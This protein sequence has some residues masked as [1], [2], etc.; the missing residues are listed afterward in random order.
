MVRESAVRTPH[1]NWKVTAVLVYG[2]FGL[3]ACDSK[4]SLQKPRHTPNILYTRILLVRTPKGR[5]HSCLE[6]IPNRPSITPYKAFQTLVLLGLEGLG[7]ESLDLGP[8]MRS[9]AGSFQIGFT[10]CSDQ[11]RVLGS[12]AQGFRG[13]L[14]GPRATQK[15]IEKSCC[16]GGDLEPNVRYSNRAA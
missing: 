2:G 11:G 10:F 12:R 6:T 14:G 1:K 15:V 13:F 3:G 9:H 16:L 5:P 7:L 8:F 4:V